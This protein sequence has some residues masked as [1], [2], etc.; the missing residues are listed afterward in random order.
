VS[1]YSVEG[2]SFRADKPREWS[3]ATFAARPRA[4]SRDLDLHP[5]GQRFAVALGTRPEAGGTLNHVVLVSNFFDELRRVA[6][7]KK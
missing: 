1:S 2:S 5:D 6:P 3:E 4:P 7:P